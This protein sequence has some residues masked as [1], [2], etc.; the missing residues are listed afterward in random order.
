MQKKRDSS[1]DRIGCLLSGQRI[2]RVPVSTFILG[3]A[4]SATGCSTADIYS[5]PQ[6]SFEAQ[7]KTRD[8]YGYDSD[9]FFGY[10]S[11]GAWEFGAKI[12]LPHGPYQQA[13]AVEGRLPVETE[14][15]VEALE[16][17]KLACDGMLP[18]AL[19]LAL[20][21]SRL[22][23]KHGMRISVVLGG[24]FTVSV[25]IASE[26]RLCRWM[27][28][29][30][31]L[32]HR[33]LRVVTDHLVG[34]LTLWAE[35]FGAVNV[36]PQLWEPAASNQIIS[37]GLFEK[38]V[39]PYQKELH[40]KTLELGIN[41]ILCHICGAHEKNLPFWREIPMGNPG[42]VSFGTE[43]PLRTAVRTFGSRCIIAGNIRPSTLQTGSKELVRTLC[44]EAIENAKD[45][46]N[47][48]ILMPGCEMPVNT[49]PSNL[50]AMI[51]ASE[52]F[53]RY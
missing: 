5:D 17:P 7:L 19:P 47:G 23:K 4:A 24:S 50:Q 8:I 21:F 30:P 1:K 10:A 18:G 28:R 33:I 16:L 48:F 15:D 35:I 51:R 44:R 39:L 14:K 53:G 46:P 27:I 9:P 3:F 25:N 12:R 38:F 36:V 29:K 11:Y 41:H 13:P 49:P 6:K 45:A 20:E 34:V 31:D 32:V 52:E 2:D 26:A 37:P 42:I 22:Q 43:V 40:E